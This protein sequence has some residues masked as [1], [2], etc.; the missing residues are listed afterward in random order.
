MGKGLVKIDNA[1]FFVISLDCIQ[2]DQA[3]PVSGDQTR[4][5]FFIVPQCA[6]AIEDLILGIDPQALVFLWLNADVVKLSQ[7]DP[8]KKAVNFAVGKIAGLTC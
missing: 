7:G 3:L 8:F 4:V 6:Q 5:L 1:L 2:V